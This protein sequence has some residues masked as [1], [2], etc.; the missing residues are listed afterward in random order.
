MHATMPRG[1]PPEDG[2]KRTKKLEVKATPEQLDR[3]DAAAAHA[4]ED[5]SEWVRHVLDE[6][7]ELGTRGLG[8]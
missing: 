3:W 6:A 8:R 7:A 1:R 4:G 2:V 5:R